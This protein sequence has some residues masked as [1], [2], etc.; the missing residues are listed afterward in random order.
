MH[1]TL[2]ENLLWWLGIGLKFLLC[3]LVFY[4]RLYRRLPF[5]S[6]YVVL[7]VVE[8]NVV[9]WV[10]REWGYGSFPA[11]YTY[12]WASAV[13][14]FARA[15]AVAELCWTSLKTYPAIWPW[16]RSLLSLIALVA[17]SYAAVTAFRNSSSPLATF[18]LASERALETAF[19]FILVALVGFGA[20]YMAVLDPVERNIVI[21]LGFYSG[22][23]VIN[24][25]FMQEWMSRYFHWWVSIRV[26]A[27]DI[28]MLAW[29]APLRKPLPRVEPGP[30]LID[31]SVAVR[32]LRELL[33]HMREITEEM[34]RIARS[35]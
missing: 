33:A 21:G 18:V 8:V 23:Q 14:L 17:L 9:W 30:T 34:K 22:F 2:S 10:Y 5:F 16:V 7:L 11:W 26:V 25:T 20:R 1:L 27:F 6:L 19:A 15:L 13:V 3:A 31:E 24:N 32:L 29:I 12:W 4:R 28:A 35:K